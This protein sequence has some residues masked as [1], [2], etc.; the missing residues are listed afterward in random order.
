[1]FLPYLQRPK[2]V[3][4]PEGAESGPLEIR[5]GLRPEIRTLNL[6]LD[7]FKHPIEVHDT[8]AEGS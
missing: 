6:L 3:E 4:A 1:M 8:E 2:N 5:R 7:L